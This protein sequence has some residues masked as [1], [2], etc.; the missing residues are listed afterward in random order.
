MTSTTALCGLNDCA[1]PVDP[2]SPI[3]RCSDCTLEWRADVTRALD[4]ERQ[5]KAAKTRRAPADAILLAQSLHRGDTGAGQVIVDH[6][7]IHSVVI[8]LA[9]YLFVTLQH[10]DIDI[11]ER[12]GV[13]LTGARAEIGEP[14]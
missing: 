6:C 7:D 4:A 3:G 2:D 10:F 12:L 13:W 14:S 9:W 1:R 8:Q 5:R 11:E